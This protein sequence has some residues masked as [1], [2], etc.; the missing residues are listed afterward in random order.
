MFKK[1]MTLI[2]DVFPKL[3]VVKEVVRKIS[4]KTRLKTLI[5]SQDVKDSQ[6]LLKSAAKH[7]YHIS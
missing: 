6:T 4:N 2:P 7:F 1:K 3:E 5:D